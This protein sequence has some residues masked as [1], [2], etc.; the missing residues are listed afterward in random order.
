MTFTNVKESHCIIR[1]MALEFAQYLILLTKHLRSAFLKRFLIVQTGNTN[2]NHS[3]N[4]TA[5]TSRA[6]NPF[7]L[8]ILPILIQKDLNG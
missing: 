7:T 4:R 2:K 6:K 1:V 8:A 5:I 3:R